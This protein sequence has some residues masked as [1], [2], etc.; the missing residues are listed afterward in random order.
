MFNMTAPSPKTYST[1]LHNS[2]CSSGLPKKRV[3]RVVDLSSETA[4]GKRSIDAARDEAE[5][6]WN[7]NLDE[8]FRS[9]PITY[10][11]IVEAITPEIQEAAT[12]AELRCRSAGIKYI[13]N[14]LKLG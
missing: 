7:C 9:K 1:N 12:D 6:R 3:E 13:I 5:R 2:T 11:E 8:R 14:K 10:A 4:V